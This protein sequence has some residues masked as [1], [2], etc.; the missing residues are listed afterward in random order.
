M[1]IVPSSI[2]VTL[3]GMPDPNNNNALEIFRGFLIQARVVGSSPQQA[4]GS[5]STPGATTDYTFHNCIT[6]QV[7]C[8]L[9]YQQY[10]N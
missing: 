5:F 8:V 9:L 10:F 4:V 6:T 3:R 1:I 7:T 2:L